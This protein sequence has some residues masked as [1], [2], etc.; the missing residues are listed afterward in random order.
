L[1]RLLA[2]VWAFCFAFVPLCNPRRLRAGDL[3]AGT[4]VVVVPKTRLLPDIGRRAA[5]GP[6][7][8]PAFT[9]AQLDAYGEYELS[10]L[11]QVLRRARDADLSGAGVVVVAERIARKIVAAAPK[12]ARECEAFLRE[13][14]GALRAR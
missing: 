2:S 12:G 11:E 4:M 5:T 3:L 14:Y 8:P 7:T 1:V 6:V 13:Y 9:D 10:V